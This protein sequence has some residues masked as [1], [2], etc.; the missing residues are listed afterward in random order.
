MNPPFFGY[1]IGKDLSPFYRLCFA[2]VLV[3]FAIQKPFSFVRSHLLIDALSACA[4]DA[5][6]E[7]LSLGRE[8]EPHSPL[9]DSGHLALKLRSLIP[10]ELSLVKDDK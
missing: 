1:V 10:L 8:F 6:S 2:P 5:L 7:R 3:S 9:S 4:V